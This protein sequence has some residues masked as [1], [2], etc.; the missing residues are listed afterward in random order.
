MPK[1]QPSHEPIRDLI[2]SLKGDRSW[3]QLTE[4]CGGTPSRRYLNLA[5]TEAPTQMPTLEHIQGLCKGLG[6]TPSVIVQTWGK[7]LGL[8]EESTWGASQYYLLDGWTELTID[9]Q[10]SIANVVKQFRA[11]NAA[12]G[13]A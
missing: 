9:Q 12:H 1:Q 2:V 3:R 8:W 13:D 7:A 10:A 6:V 11:A 4:D 5:T